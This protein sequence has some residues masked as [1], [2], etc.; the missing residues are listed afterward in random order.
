MTEQKTGRR[1]LLNDGTVFE[2]GECGEW[3]GN[4]WCT[5]PDTTI[6]VVSAKF[7]D[8]D[9]TKKIV[10]EYGEMSDTY[11]GYTNVTVIMKSGNSWKVSLTK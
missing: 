5:I 2:N 4:L 3:E 10:F 9:A 11:K 7:T 8:P 1:L 6:I